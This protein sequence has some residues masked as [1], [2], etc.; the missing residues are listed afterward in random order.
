MELFF[1]GTGAGSPSRERNVTSIALDLAVERGK[2]WLFDCGEGTQHQILKS[3]LKLSRLEFLFVTHLHG[4]H[5]Y[6]IPGLLTSRS[7]QGG[8]TPLVIYGPPGIRSYV[9]HVLSIS[10]AHLDY[11][12]RMEEIE[13]GTVFEDD[14]FVIETARLEHRIESF[15]Y[16]VIEKPKPGRLL[17]DKLREAGLPPGPQYAE[18]KS[19]RDIQMPDG[20]ILKSSDYVSP[21][22]EGRIVTIMGDTRICANARRLSHQADVLVHEATFA[23]DKADL[24]YKYYHCTSEEAARMAQEEQVGTLVMTHISSRYQGTDIE[25]LQNEA[26]KYIK[27]AYVAHDF[28]RF[29]IPPK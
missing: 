3:S 25:I 26:R 19:G 18:I 13:P 28:W 21:M 24:A 20:R 6:G 27:N 8:E 29:P 7:Y 1:L 22:T 4:D 9:E 14:Q 5:I 2:L 12:L 10:K 17:S 11:E 15:G 23:G 16:R